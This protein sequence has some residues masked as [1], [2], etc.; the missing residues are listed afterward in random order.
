MYVVKQDSSS[1]E[2]VDWTSSN[3]REFTDVNVLQL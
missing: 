2:W 3:V 1:D